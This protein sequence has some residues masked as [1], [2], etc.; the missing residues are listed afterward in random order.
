MSEKLL[1]CKGQIIAGQ[2]QIICAGSKVD[3]QKILETIKK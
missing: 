2:K 1:I 3:T